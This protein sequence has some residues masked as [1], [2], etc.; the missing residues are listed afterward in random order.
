MCF[1]AAATKG[2]A[3]SELLFQVGE[4]RVHLVEVANSTSD[5]ELHFCQWNGAFL[6]VLVVQR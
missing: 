2:E 5:P 6:N 1:L 4:G 3:L